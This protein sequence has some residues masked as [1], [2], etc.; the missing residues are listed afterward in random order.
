MRKLIV[1]NIMSL[2]GSYTG[3]GNDVMALPMDEAFDAYNVARLRA[4]DTLLLGRKTYE[5]FK[6]FW[7]SVA[8]DPKAS[9][10]HRK[11][12]RLNNAIDKV[13]ISDSLVWNQRNHGLTLAS[14]VAETLTSK[15]QNSNA[16]P[17]KT[18]WFLAATSCRMGSFISAIWARWCLPQD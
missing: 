18:S 14:S 11:I 6:G 16:N 3:P 10:T 8:D 5:G 13:V 9:P 7:P 1:S 12:S 2:D 17:A 15:S 4:A